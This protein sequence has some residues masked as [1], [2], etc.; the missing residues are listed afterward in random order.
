MVAQAPLYHHVLS[1]L[2]AGMKM[3]HWMWFIFPQIR[4]LGRSPI[5]IEYA[6]ASRDEAHA[7]LHHSV[8]GLRLKECT[9]VVLLVEGRSAYEI[10]GTPDDI[11]FRSSM[12][13]FAAVSQDDD[14]FERALQKYF[15]GVPDPLTLD[16][17]Q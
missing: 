15:N 8:L 6:I 11:K 17:L 2:A 13:L 3:G 10:F 16:R 14:I 1:E 5:S 4:G 12:T 7:Y 9:R